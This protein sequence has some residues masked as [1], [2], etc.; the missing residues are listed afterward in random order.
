MAKFNASTGRFLT[1]V[2]DLREAN[3]DVCAEV[4]ALAD[5]YLAGW[6][7]KDFGDE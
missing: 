3:L 5:R 2:E 7:P 6:E 4:I 1:Y